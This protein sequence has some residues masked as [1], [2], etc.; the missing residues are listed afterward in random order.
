[1]QDT[2]V[3]FSLPAFKDEEGQPVTVIIVEAAKKSMPTFM[4]F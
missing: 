3:V 4:M 1:M 2:S